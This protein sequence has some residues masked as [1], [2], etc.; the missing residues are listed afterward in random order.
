MGRIKSKKYSGVYLNHLLSGDITYTV[1]YK[2][3]HN[4]KVFYKIGKKS[5]G[6]TEVYAY[7]K[8]NEFIN[9]V[10]L[11][12]DPLAHKK[13][14]SIITIDN[15]AKVYFDDK[16]CMVCENCKAFDKLSNN[17]KKTNNSL[18]CTYRKVKHQMT[19]QY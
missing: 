8:R 4:K 7:N 11:G 6:I 10:R 19:P 18:V 15:L 9:Q 1:T 17:A 14:K 2:D 3:E 13:K 5:E 16:R 12:E